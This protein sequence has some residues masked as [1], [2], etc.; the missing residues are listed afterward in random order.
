MAPG[1]YYVTEV[2]NGV[3]YQ[4]ESAKSATDYREP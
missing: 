3:N 2:G 4:G 1:Y